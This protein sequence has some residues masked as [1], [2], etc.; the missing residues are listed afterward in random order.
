MFFAALS[1]AFSPRD[2]LKKKSATRVG[3]HLSRCPKRAF[4]R[5][6]LK[7]NP[8]CIS[9]MRLHLSHGSPRVSFRTILSSLAC[10]AASRARQKDVTFCKVRELPPNKDGRLHSIFVYRSN[11][12]IESVL[13]MDDEH[14]ILVSLRNR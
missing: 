4:G 10:F 2:A 7:G 8:R 11:D 3:D 5:S 12:V 13:L 1:G 14:N 9:W 6:S